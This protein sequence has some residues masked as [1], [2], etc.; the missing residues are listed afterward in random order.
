MRFCTFDIHVTVITYA[1]IY[2]ISALEGSEIVS[3]NPNSDHDSD[4][5]S[6]RNSDCNPNAMEGVDLK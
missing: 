4:R 3:D 2:C 6:D 1:C 5:D